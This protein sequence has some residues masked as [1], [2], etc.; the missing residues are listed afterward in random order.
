MNRNERAGAPAVTRNGTAD[1]AGA[2]PE[3]HRGRAGGAP[4]TARGRARGETK[5]SA[6]DMRLV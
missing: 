2:G 4:G 1:G 3:W 5:K 6:V